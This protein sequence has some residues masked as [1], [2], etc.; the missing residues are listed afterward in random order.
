MDET[1]WRGKIFFNCNRIA[2]R[3]YIRSDD[4]GYPMI[5]VSSSRE[6]LESI[7]CKVSVDEEDID[8]N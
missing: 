3:N 8:T 2:L 1:S 4:V 6:R 7:L 5:E